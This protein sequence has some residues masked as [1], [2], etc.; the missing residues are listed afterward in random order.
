MILASTPQHVGSR[1]PRRRPPPWARWTAFLVLLAAVTAAHAETQEYCVVCTGPVA[2]YR[3][4]FAGG[5]ANHPGLQLHCI[6]T[7]AREGGHESCAIGRASKTPCQG[8]LKVLNLPEAA[9]VPPAAADAPMTAPGNAGASPPAAAIGEPPQADVE[10]QG[11]RTP[12]SPAPV[13]ATPAP[14]PG[15]PGPPDTDKAET[16]ETAAGKK[17]WSEGSGAPAAPAGETAPD[18]PETADEAPPAQPDL[19]KPL[20]D[21]GKAVGDAAKKTGSALEKAGDAVGHA[22]KKTWKCLTSLFGDC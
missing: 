9:P 12:P 8:V 21:A 2:Q 10:M 1:S 15:E 7:L 19:V 6:S 5:G 18:A 22:A 3:C 14:A 13:T 4:T 16:G 17:Q 11:V 20:K